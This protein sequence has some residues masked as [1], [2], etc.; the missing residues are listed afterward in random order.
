MKKNQFNLL[1]IFSIVFSILALLLYFLDLLV[2]FSYGNYPV[3]TQN[4]L[5]ISV[6]V[7]ALAITYCPNKKCFFVISGAGYLFCTI[8]LLYSSFNGGWNTLIFI[9]LQLNYVGLYL[10]RLLYLKANQNNFSI[11]SFVKENVILRYLPLKK[12]L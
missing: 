2:R 6:A 8:V 1:R 12:S 7:S 9:L 10:V 3:V 4:V 11:K 5:L